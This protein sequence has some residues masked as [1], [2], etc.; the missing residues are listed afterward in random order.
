MTADSNVAALAVRDDPGVT[1]TALI[2]P[3]ADL[4]TIKAAFAEYQA[5]RMQLLEKSDFQKI[6]RRE[7]PKKSAWRKLSTAFGVSLSIVSK[8]HTREGGRIVRSEFV[9]RATASNGRF[10]EG[11]GLCD[12]HEKCCE[13]GCTKGS[14]HFHCPARSGEECTGFRHFSHAEH[15]IPATAETRAKN[16]AASDLFGMGEVSAEEILGAGEVHDGTG[17]DY[18]EGEVVEEQPAKGQRPSGDP[19]KL[20]T[21]IFNHPKF[22]T[23]KGKPGWSI[24]EI[25]KLSPA[26]M[27]AK[28]GELEGKPPAQ[29]APEP[30]P[31]PA[32]QATPTE[33]E[34]DW[35][36]ERK[37]AFARD[38]IE[39]TPGWEDKYKAIYGAVVEAAVMGQDL[40]SLNDVLDHMRAEGAKP[41]EVVEQ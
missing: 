15:D 30:V 20:K 1:G 29:P 36:L 9:C 19:N 27:A 39:G 26:A 35:S 6:G 8:D 31:E 12:V 4:A 23:R 22:K 21:T 38:T 33:T 18:I 2:R 17:S 34:I 25:S 5:L 10:A 3:A 40:E 14:G 13:P 41:A 11:W 16:R 7:H 28:L 24:P 32:S 37:I